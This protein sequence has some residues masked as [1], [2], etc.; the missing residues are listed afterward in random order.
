[1][2][3]AIS[4]DFSLGCHLN[5]HLQVVSPCSLGFFIAWQPQGGRTSYMVVQGSKSK[6]HVIRCRSC[7]IFSELASVVSHSI[8]SV[9]FYWLQVK[10]KA[11]QD[12]KG[13]GI[14][15]TSP[16]SECQVHMLDT[17]AAIF[18]KYNLLYMCS[19]QFPSFTKI[20]GV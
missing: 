10:H 17:A 5:Y 16:W 2:A 14:D 19:I 8:T 7:I 3:R 20:I 13:N 15:P 4:W 12:S 6:C 18:E 9:A 11:T 1:M